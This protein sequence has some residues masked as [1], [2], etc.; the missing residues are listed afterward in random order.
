[1]PFKPKFS[2]SSHLF[3]GKKENDDFLEAAACGICDPGD[4]VAATCAVCGEEFSSR[5]KMFQHI[6]AT[7]HAALKE[8][9]GQQGAA[10]GSKGKKKKR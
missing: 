1:L 6:K 4:P 10:G 2:Y 9:P 7:G 3:N 8:V 5:T